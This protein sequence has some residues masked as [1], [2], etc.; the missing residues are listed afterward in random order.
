MLRLKPHWC[1]CSAGVG[2][3][4]ICM[5]NVRLSKNICYPCAV[6][7]LK[8]L[9]EQEPDASGVIPAPRALSMSQDSKAMLGEG[10]TGRHS[11]AQPAQG[12]EGTI[13]PGGASIGVPPSG[14]QDTSGA[15]KG[16]SGQ[17][18]LANSEGRDAKGAD[19]AAAERPEGQGIQGK[20]S[21]GPLADR[22]SAGGANLGE[23]EALD[24]SSWG[25]DWSWRDR[26]EFNPAGEQPQGWRWVLARLR[27]LA[28]EERGPWLRT[29]TWQDR[30]TGCVQQVKRITTLK[31]ALTW[32]AF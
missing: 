11:N 32:S 18:A 19:S 14:A 25:D 7:V 29:L 16:S 28:V 6:D 2:V 10:L 27:A 24:T 21:G 4:A 17:E 3:A 31:C 8:T 20:P 12:L 26:P 13:G 22:L 23:V 15:P 5:V 9:L 30:I 1:C